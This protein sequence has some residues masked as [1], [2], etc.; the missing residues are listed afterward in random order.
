VADASS[1]WNSFTVASLV[2][3]FLTPVLLFA[4][5]VI[6]TRAARRIEDAQW[7]GRKLIERRLELHKEMA[8][9]LNDVYCFFAT[10]GHF[11]EITPPD[12]LDK[13][14]QLDK[15]FHT[16]KNLFSAEF[17]ECYYEFM[18]SCFIEYSPLPEDA[19][20]NAQAARMREQRSYKGWD[21]QW[22][23]R[24]V[25]MTTDESKET[26]ERQKR[27]YEALMSAFATD[28]GVVRPSSR[29]D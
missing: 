7:A 21:P 28:L 6:V 9:V 26:A 2:I 14:R 8:P 22:D 29:P 13:K 3:A 20:L 16:N 25:E 17:Q 4:L 10:R 19:H 27:N 24:F 23:D 11:R 5:G 15:L 1:P 12:A 18:R